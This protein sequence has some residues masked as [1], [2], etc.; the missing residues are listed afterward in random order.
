VKPPIVNGTVRRRRSAAFFHD[1]DIDAIIE[2]IPSCRDA[3]GGSSYRRI[4]V[5]VHVRAKLA[6]SR[7]GIVNTAGPETER[8]LNSE[9]Y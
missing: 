5:G 2:T 1:G 3:G 7:A 8:L 6:G 4:T 9:G